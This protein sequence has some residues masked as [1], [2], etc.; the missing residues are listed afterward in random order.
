MSEKRILFLILASEDSIH[1]AD[2][3]IQQ[4]TWCSTLPENISALWIRG[5]KSNEYKLSG[6]D[7]YVPCQESYE[8]ILTK[9][10]LAMTW[11]VENLSFEILIR[12]NISTYYSIPHLIK[13]LR[14]FDSKKELLG[15]FIDETRSLS[16]LE[17]KTF[18]FV[19]GT[20]IYLTQPAC[21]V[22]I[23]LKPT[24]YLG[25]PDD[26]AIT[27]FLGQQGIHPHFFHRVNLHSTHI[28]ILGSQI[29][30]K[31]SEISDLARKRFSLI[32]KYSQMPRSIRK[33]RCY[34]QIEIQEVSNIHL[35]IIH[36]ESFMRRNFHILYQNIRYFEI[37]KNKGCK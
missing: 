2:R 15:G 9:T 13:E 11:C 4:R 16:L 1:E 12:T 33:I 37:S 17:D 24:N 19:T 29:R 35:G 25:I 32:F 8:N 34:L 10:I 36:F 26:V 20:G 23:N 5:H 31:S 22:L 18:S 30:L 3:E 28:F 14:N 6:V 21:R 27:Y 7:L